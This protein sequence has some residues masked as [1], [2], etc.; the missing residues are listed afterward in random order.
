M[1]PFFRQ[2]STHNPDITLA[3]VSAAGWIKKEDYGDP[4]HVLG[5]S[6]RGEREAQTGAGHTR[7][8][9]TKETCA[10]GSKCVDI[11]QDSQTL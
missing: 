8:S 1:T 5:K 10:K 2:L 4:P 11:W 9:G 7:S 6:A 3:V